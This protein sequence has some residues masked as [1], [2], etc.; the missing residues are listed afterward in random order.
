MRVLSLPFLALM[1]GSL[2]KPSL[3]LSL[4]LLFN[5]TADFEIYPLSL[6]DALPICAAPARRSRP[7]RPARA[8]SRRPGAPPPAPRSEEHTSE[9]QSRV[10]L[11]CRLLLEK[12]KKATITSATQDSNV[13]T[14]REAVACVVSGARATS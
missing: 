11:V 7:G 4:V 2:L 8:R 10:D 3:V 13:P 9:L 12:K 6:H 1:S 14:S 5:L